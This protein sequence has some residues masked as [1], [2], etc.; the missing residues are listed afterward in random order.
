MSWFVSVTRRY[1]NPSGFTYERR[2]F[3]PFEYALQPPAWYK[4]NHMAVNKP[5]LPE[6]IQWTSVFTFELEK[7]K[8]GEND[9][10]T[11]KLKYQMVSVEEKCSYCHHQNGVGVKP[12]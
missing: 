3:C 8:V 1:P 7:N 11:I 9:S 12:N 5:V 4:S 6:G 10:V 2:F